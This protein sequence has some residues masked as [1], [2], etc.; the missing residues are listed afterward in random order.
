MCLPDCKF[1]LKY[2]L[3]RSAVVHPALSVDLPASE[4]RSD[5]VGGI[6]SF[7]DLVMTI[8]NHSSKMIN[9]HRYSCDSVDREVS[10]N[11]PGKVGQSTHGLRKLVSKAKFFNCGF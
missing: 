5:L 8:P 10:L 3:L 6:I 4:Y 9:A 2:Y 11:M 1:D 7:L